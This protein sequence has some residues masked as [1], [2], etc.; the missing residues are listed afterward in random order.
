MDSVEEVLA[1]VGI[2]SLRTFGTIVAIWFAYY[3]SSLI[4][5]VSP[6]HPLSKFPGPRLAA[7]SYAYEFW[8]DMVQKGRY[9]HEIKR[10]HEIYGAN[11]RL[12]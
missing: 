3:I 7:A 12:H 10:L 11:S 6:L 9:T 8:F 4:Y 5:N 1:P 2:L